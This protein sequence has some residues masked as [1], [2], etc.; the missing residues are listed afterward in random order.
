[1]TMCC[2][3]KSSSSHCRLGVVAVL[4]M[5][6]QRCAASLLDTTKFTERKFVSSASQAKPGIYLRIPEQPMQEAFIHRMIFFPE[7]LFIPFECIIDLLKSSLGAHLQ[8]STHQRKAAGVEQQ[9]EH[10]QM[11]FLLRNSFSPHNY[12]NSWILSLTLSLCLSQTPTYFIP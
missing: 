3:T 11:H 2:W 7:F 1:M 4:R 10:L 6:V 12:H 5:W 9:V 8:T